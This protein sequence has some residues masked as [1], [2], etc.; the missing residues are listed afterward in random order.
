MFCG[1]QTFFC[2]TEPES[3][4]AQRGKAT[5]AFCVEPRH[6]FVHKGEIKAA[7]IN[8]FILPVDQM[9]DV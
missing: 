9:D 1:T 4:G 2:L 3:G 7:L 6:T 5:L 8:T